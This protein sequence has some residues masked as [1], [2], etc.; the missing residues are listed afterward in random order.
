MQ[1]IDTRPTC[2]PLDS[3]QQPL[4]NVVAGDPSVRRELESLIRSVGWQPRTAAS[5][6]EF[7]DRPRVMAPTCL[8]VEQHLPGLGGLELQTL[9]LDRVEMP[10]IFLG[11]RPDQRATVQ[12]MK[13]GAF[14]FLLEPLEHP[15]LLS[16]IASAL[17]H[18]RAA[19]PHATRGI[20][21]QQCY[22]SLSQREREVMDL[23]VRGRLNKQVGLEL[24]ISEITVKAHRG[25]VMRKIRARSVAE[26]VTMAARLQSSTAHPATSGG[27]S[28]LPP[29][30]R[31][32]GAMAAYAHA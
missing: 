27:C 22:E 3:L 11:T 6:E 7:L 31:H 28:R 9:L 16:V 4:I 18:S 20:A 23:V 12:A 29:A 2:R 17:E 26:L 10:V 19:L 5:A 21:L 32:L 8:L 13:A 24:G 15:V 25:K 1:P 14:D 30:N